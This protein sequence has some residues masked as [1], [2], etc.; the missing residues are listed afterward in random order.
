M[1]SGEVYRASKEKQFYFLSVRR[2]CHCVCHSLKL[3][4]FSLALS[5]LRIASFWLIN[6]VHCTHTEQGQWNPRKF[7]KSF[8]CQLIWATPKAEKIIRTMAPG[9]VC[10]RAGCRRWIRLL[11]TTEAIKLVDF[12]GER[13]DSALSSTERLSQ[14]RRMCTIVKQ[15]QNEERNIIMR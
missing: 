11:W 5:A 15:Q 4:S 1:Q 6:N 12:G 14:M 8:L 2:G 3:F 7:E 9:A 13:N 10:F